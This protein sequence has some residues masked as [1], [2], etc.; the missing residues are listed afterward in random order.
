MRA[1]T[2]ST[3]LDEADGGAGRRFLVFPDIRSGNWQVASRV[4]HVLGAP[5]RHGVAGT[6]RAICCLA[7]PSQ[8]GRFGTQFSQA[9]ISLVGLEKAF[10]L[11]CVFRCLI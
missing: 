2:I 6:V 3:L 5:H 7:Q 11:L 1:G 4:A 8:S 9:K 10:N